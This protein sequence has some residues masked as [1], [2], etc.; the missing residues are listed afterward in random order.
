MVS[1]E[2]FEESLRVAVA[3]WHSAGFSV[4]CLDKAEAAARAV[5]QGSSAGCRA[6]EARRRQLEPDNR[7]VV[8]RLGIEDF[9]RPLHESGPPKSVS[10]CDLGLVL[11]YPERGGIFRCK[12]RN[13]GRASA[14]YCYLDAE[15]A[16]VWQAIVKAIE[17][18]QRERAEGVAVN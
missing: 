13:Q 14:W 1:P 16:A 10:P 7:T 6:G 9:L 17:E 5:Y 4:P 11:G 15:G 8:E 2:I 12:T 3:E 18:L